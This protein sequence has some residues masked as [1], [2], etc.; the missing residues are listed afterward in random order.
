MM[1]GP[2][3]LAAAKGTRLGRDTALPSGMVLPRGTVIGPSEIA[4]LTMAGLREVICAELDPHDIVA[5][6]ALLRLVEA[7]V[8]HEADAGL[9]RG[10]PAGG[11]LILTATVTG[12]V[13]L[14]TEGLRR[15]NRVDPGL[16]I[17]TVSQFQ[18]VQAGERVAVLRALPLALRRSAL[19]R[20]LA[21]GEDMIRL[22]PVLAEKVTLIQ[23]VV[24]AAPDSRGEGAIRARLARLGLRLTE[25]LIVT[26]R[27]EALAETLLAA[28]GEVVLILPARPTAD[29]L[30][31][32]P[33]A[34][35]QAG[36]VIT[37][38]G[39]PVAPG[40]EMFAGGLGAVPIL[41]LPG[42]MRDTAE[43]GADRVLDRLL[44]GV[45]ISDDD[46]ADLG[47]GGLQSGPNAV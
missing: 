1:F 31:V 7:L 19:S 17:A 38:F 34:V 47:V 39:L 8:P 21:E 2:R 9:R 4:A 14:D 37:R 44:C 13:G 5:D 22:R 23:T 45:S 16:S 15:M 25:S 35:T 46:L 40:A 30:D 29:L 3:P 32:G 42:A 20:V 27:A 36:G 33:L 11:Q 24:G 28:H 6:D 12:V 43:N 18:R 26:H 41:G 10:R